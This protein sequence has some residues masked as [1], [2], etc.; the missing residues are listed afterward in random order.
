MAAAATAKSVPASDSLLKALTD[1][2]KK[3]L[4]MSQGDSVQDL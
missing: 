2:L 3:D 4:Q 1:D